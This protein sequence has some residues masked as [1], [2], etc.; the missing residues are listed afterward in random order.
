[1]ADDWGFFHTSTTNLQRVKDAMGRVPVLSEEQRSEIARKADRVIGAIE[2]EP[3][4]WG[5]KLR[6]RT[7]TKKIWY[8][9]VTDWG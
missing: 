2:A 3:K 4:S 9:E 6:S 1:M 5:W 7:G 8:K